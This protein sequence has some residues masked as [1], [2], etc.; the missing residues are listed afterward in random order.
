[1]RTVNDVPV[2]LDCGVHDDSSIDQKCVP[3]L[4]GFQRCFA[5]VA[6]N[7]F[8]CYLLQVCNEFN[9]VILNVL[10]I[11][12]SSSHNA[13]SGNFTYISN[14]ICTVIDYLIVSETLLRI[15]HLLSA[16]P[17]VESKHMP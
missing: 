17:I 6:I 10:K 7:V 2:T 13:F 11:L 3:N 4:C 15:C 14:T 16:L 5:D 8:G 12:H 9:L 1:M